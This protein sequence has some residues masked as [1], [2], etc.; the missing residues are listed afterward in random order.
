[1]VFENVAVGQVAFKQRLDEW[2]PHQN[3]TVA[4]GQHQRTTLVDLEFSV[5]THEPVDL[6]GAKQYP[7]K[8]SIRVIQTP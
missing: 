1:M 6:D 2:T 3:R 4:L 8:T 5:V 7:R